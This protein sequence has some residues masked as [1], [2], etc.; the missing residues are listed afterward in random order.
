MDDIVDANDVVAGVRG[1]RPLFGDRVTCYVV[2][3]GVN[4]HAIQPYCRLVK[5]V[6]QS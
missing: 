5:P 3:N 2:D 6:G 1:L 4:A